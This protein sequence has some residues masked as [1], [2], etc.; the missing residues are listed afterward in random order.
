MV[1]SRVAVIAADFG[2][3]RPTDDSLD[4]SPP[5]GSART[6]DSSSGCRSATA[7]ATTRAADIDNRRVA[8]AE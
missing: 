8:M 2:V 4:G 3:T 5:D 1:L 6:A 7:R